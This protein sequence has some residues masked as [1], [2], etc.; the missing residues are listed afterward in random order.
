MKVFCKITRKF[1]VSVS[2]ANIREGTKNELVARKKIS[3]I[4]V[5]VAVQVQRRTALI[6]G[7]KNDETKL[8][9]Q[10]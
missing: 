6:S 10:K 5:G 8:G 2:L 4:E 9:S 7:K 3:R 1:A